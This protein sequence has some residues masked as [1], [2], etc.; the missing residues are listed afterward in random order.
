MPASAWDRIFSDPCLERARHRLSADEVMTIIRHVWAAEETGDKPLK[1]TVN[2]TEVEWSDLT[3]SHEQICALAKQPPHASA[4]YSYRV[5]GGNG[6]SGVTFA[7]RTISV[8][9]GME[10]DCVATGNA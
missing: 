7:G 1:I 10:I 5:H 3:I 9:P 8:F 6:L 4:T 2:G